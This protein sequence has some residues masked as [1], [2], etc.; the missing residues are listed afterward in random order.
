MKYKQPDFFAPSRIFRRRTVTAL[1]FLLVMAALPCV[2]FAD[3]LSDFFR[4]VKNDNYTTVSSLLQ[5]G[6]SP[7]LVEETRGD[8]GLILALREDSNRVFNILLNTPGIDL[9]VRAKNGD[10]ALMIAAYKA[11]VT[12]VKALLAKEAQV[13]NPGWTALHYAAAVGNDDI[14][15]MLLEESAYIDAESPNSTT[16]LMMAASKGRLSTV[17]LLLEE[18]ADASLKNNVGMTALDFAKDASQTLVLDD[19][20]K[21]LDKSGKP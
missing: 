1:T 12:A 7:N 2:A 11:N 3:T 9:E 19:M 14:V 21:L 15:R 4:A 17:K 6:L 16:P 13:N 5:R 20:T 10:T 18:G 8:T